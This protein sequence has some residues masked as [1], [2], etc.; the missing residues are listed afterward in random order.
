MKKLLMLL[1]VGVAL[2][3]CKKDVVR[4]DTPELYVIDDSEAAEAEFDALFS[5]ASESDNDIFSS[6]AYLEIDRTG[7]KK[8]YLRI[9]LVGAQAAHNIDI[10]LPTVKT[11][12]YHRAL[13]P[14]Y[15]HVYKNWVEGKA[16]PSFKHGIL[17][18]SGS[19]VPARYTFV[20]EDNDGAV[21]SFYANPEDYT[22]PAGDYYDPSFFHFPASSFVKATYYSAGSAGGKADYDCF[23]ADYS[24]VHPEGHVDFSIILVVNEAFSDE[25]SKL[26]GTYSITGTTGDH[27]WDGSFIVFYNEWE[28]ETHKDFIARGVLDG[29]ELGYALVSWKQA[30]NS[31]LTLSASCIPTLTY[32]S[33]DKSIIE[34]D[35][36]TIKASEV[37]FI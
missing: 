15:C 6:T 9:R 17:R 19:G 23:K 2:V 13:K 20:F 24:T 35:Y 18:V 5:R 4:D 37:T 8:P 11:D 33:G 12:P 3:A 7:S 28:E 27:M 34:V 14:G 32:A 10:Y 21:T 25:L 1:F 26:Q 30:T 16:A 31:Y 22:F 29:R 36:T